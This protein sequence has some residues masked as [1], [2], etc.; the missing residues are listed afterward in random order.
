MKPDK[1]H[2][3]EDLPILTFYTS[4]AALNLC[5][6]DNTGDLLEV[7]P[8]RKRHTMVK[9]LLHAR[10]CQTDIHHTLHSHHL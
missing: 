6:V 7:P 8:Q 1:Q 9:F 3:S 10:P 5:H 4:I 2:A